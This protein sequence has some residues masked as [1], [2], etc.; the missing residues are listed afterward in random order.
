[1]E[2]ETSYF[3][4][5]VSDLGTPEHRPICVTS[6]HPT[7]PAGRELKSRPHSGAQGRFRTGLVNISGL[8]LPPICSDGSLPQSNTVSTCDIHSTCSSILASPTLVPPPT[9]PMRKLLPSPASPGIPVDPREQNTPSQSIT[10]SWVAS[11]NRYYQAS[12]ISQQSR[13]TLTAAWRKN[14]PSAYFSAWTEWR[15]W[16]GQ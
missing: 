4:S 7:G 14:T 11:V 10:P 2:A 15:S 9:G 12:A 1:M 16:C 3:Q 6:N 13:E 5:S 8:R